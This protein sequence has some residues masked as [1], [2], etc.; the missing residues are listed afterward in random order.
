MFGFSYV[1]AVGGAVALLSLVGC[2]TVIDADIFTADVLDFPDGVEGL[3]APVVVGVDINDCDEKGPTMVDGL[4]ASFDQVEFI[5][6]VGENF[7]ELASFRT[8][9][10]Y[11][12][13]GDL[14][15]RA[16]G[17]RVQRGAAD[18]IEVWLI[19]DPIRM[20][21]IWDQLPEDMTKYRKFDPE[22]FIEATLNNDLRESVSVT[23]DDVF[24]DG[25][26]IQGTQNF[27]LP[28]RGQVRIQLSDVSN[29]AFKDVDH[30]A[31]IATFLVLTD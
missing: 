30:F 14:Q 5:G 31:H 2:K 27:E 24:A 21:A 4:S 3:T 16:L 11:V 10:S 28:R 26:A 1:R 9:V 22:F 8:Q 12:A 7:N 29:I 15:G 17:I 6:C 25:A 18:E 23:T 19:K 20:R 13:D